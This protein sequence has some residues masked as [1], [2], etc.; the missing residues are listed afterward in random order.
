MELLNSIRNVK[1]N[2]IKPIIGVEA[3]L[4]P[5]TI[6][7]KTPKIDSKSYHLTLLAKN[8]QGY[9]NL[10]KLITIANLEGFYYKPRIDKNLL[11]EHSAGLICFLD[12]L[13][14]EISRSILNNV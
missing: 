11:K 1:K 6:Y 9:L 3:Y 5:R 2:E 14:R 13:A 7:D 4:A 8:Y 12:A 10:I